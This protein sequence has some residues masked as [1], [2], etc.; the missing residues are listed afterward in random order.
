MFYF[1]MGQALV[2]LPWRWRPLLLLLRD[3]PAVRANLYHGGRD[4]LL[5]EPHQQHLLLHQEWHQFRCVKV[6][7]V[8]WIFWLW[9][10]SALTGATANIRLKLKSAF[11]MSCFFLIPSGVAFTDLPVSVFYLLFRNFCHCCG[12]FQAPHRCCWF[13][14]SFTEMLQFVLI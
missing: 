14:S 1:R 4:W 10:P 11:D 12:S 3:G 9:R 6:P 2:R 5:R 13:W 8:R 7:R